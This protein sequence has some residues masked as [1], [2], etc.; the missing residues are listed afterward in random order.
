MVGGHCGEDMADPAEQAA[1]P[2][3]HPGR[4]DEPEDATPEVAVI[5]LTEAGQNRAEDRRDARVFRSGHAWIVRDAAARTRDC[6]GQR[7]RLSAPGSGI[8]ISGSPLTCASVSTS[9]RCRI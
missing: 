3:P 7:S 9:R 5:K 4:D 6:L 8:G 1:R 2:D